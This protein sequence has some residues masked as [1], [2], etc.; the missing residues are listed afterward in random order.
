MGSAL[1]NVGPETPGSPFRPRPVWTFVAPTRAER[2]SVRG[3]RV[4]HAEDPDGT[5]GVTAVLFD[6]PV[7]AVVDVRGG[8]SATYDTAS[9]SVEATFGRRWALFLAG[10][11]LFGLDAA[12]GIRTRIL[13]TGGGHRTFGSPFRL[14]PISGAALFDLPRREGPLPEYLA[15]GYEAART[16]GEGPVREGRVGAGAGATVGKY[17]G[18]ARAMRGGLALRVS[19]LGRRAHVGVVVAVNAVGAVRD[20]STGRWVAGARDRRGRVVPPP[21]TLSP[22]PAGVGTTL[23][24]V[25]TDLAVERPAL[26]RIAAIVHGGLARSIVPY[27]TSV[28]GD[29]VFAAAT[30]AAGRPP[31]ARYPGANADTLGS[32]AAE[33][34][35]EAVLAAVRAANRAR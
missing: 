14:A 9:L 26:A 32:L 22:L 6:G 28:D 34:A 20:P 18:R 8:A 1:I 23:A 4:G 5:S 19:A 12:R 21:P 24:I 16:A 17:F 33:C 11:S 31:R 2:G 3:V 29:V 15:L 30:G 25:F 35:A 13:E 27:Q 7:P 10:G